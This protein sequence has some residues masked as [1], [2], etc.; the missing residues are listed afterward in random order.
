L[1]E[2]ALRDLI[3][4]WVAPI[5]Q[6]RC[7]HSDLREALTALARYLTTVTLTPQ[8]IAINRILVSESIRRPEFA[9]L[10]EESGRKVAVRTIASILRRHETELK[11]VDFDMAAEQFIC[12]TL[13]D[14]FRI[15]MLNIHTSSKKVERW[16]ASCVDLFL[17]G[18]GRTRQRT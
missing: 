15:A 5:A 16:V 11:R 12:L 18:I 7:D 1:F 6:I 9:K 17:R 2:A 13:D 3:D 10:A 8:S 4:R 14:R